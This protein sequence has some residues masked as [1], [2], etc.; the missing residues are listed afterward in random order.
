[1]EIIQN[2]RHKIDSQCIPKF[3]L[4]PHTAR[5]QTIKK[6]HTNE[7]YKKIIDFY[8]FLFLVF[9][10]ADCSNM[11]RAFAVPLQTILPP[12]SH[13]ALPS[14]LLLPT[15]TLQLQL[16]LLSGSC[17]WL[18]SSLTKFLLCLKLASNLH[19]TKRQVPHSFFFNKSLGGSAN[20]IYLC[21]SVCVQSDY[22]VNG[23]ISSINLGRI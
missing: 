19:L 6:K 17:G 10:L 18:P 11:G 21:Q 3:L 7:I 23:C 5:M 13:L 9:L 2:I 8:E 16:K 12:I 15:H 22:N 20:L 4:R 1:M 14:L